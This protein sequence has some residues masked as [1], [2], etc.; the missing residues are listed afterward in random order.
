M[1]EPNVFQGV[2]P[3]EMVITIAEYEEMKK[4]IEKSKQYEEFNTNIRNNLREENM[5]IQEKL[6]ILEKENIQLKRGIINYI[7]TLGGKAN[8]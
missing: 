8:D 3:D 4:Q 5:K 6:T 1:E 2:G 7:K